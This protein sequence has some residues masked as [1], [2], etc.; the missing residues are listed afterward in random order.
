[1]WNTDRDGTVTFAEMGRYIREE[2]VFG[3][4]QRSTAWAGSGFRKQM[5]FVTA[6]P[7]SHPWLGE[8]VMTWSDGK[9][10]KGKWWKAKVHRV[11]DGLDFVRYDGY[12]ANWDEWVGPYRIRKDDYAAE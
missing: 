4:E 2:T 6:P 5:N 1:M 3:D 10:W 9:K 12:D 11:G 8:R 7:L